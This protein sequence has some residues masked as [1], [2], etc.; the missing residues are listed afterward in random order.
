MPI[1]DY[2]CACGGKVID[3]YFSTFAASPASVTCPECGQN[4]AARVI[5]TKNFIHPSL[6]TMYGR[7]EPALGGDVLV[8]YAHKQ[9]VLRELGVQEASD[10]VHGAKL[11]RDAVP[12]PPPRPAPKDRMVWA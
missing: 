6:S 5:G 7:P 4:T 11:Y 1:Y 2:Q 12:A 3:A 8:D 9:R 10:R